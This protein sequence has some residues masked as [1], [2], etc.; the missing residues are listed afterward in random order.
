MRTYHPIPT[1]DL[2][3]YWRM[4]ADGVH[5]LPWNTPPIINIKGIGL[6]D[7][8]SMIIFTSADRAH[9]LSTY[10]EFY[11]LMDRDGYFRY[12]H[13]DNRSEIILQAFGTY[14]NPNLELLPQGKLLEFKR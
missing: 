4:A 10:S 5:P 12:V 11:R 13:P 9:H 1:S 8:R 2:R 14:V 3:A 6:Y 7:V